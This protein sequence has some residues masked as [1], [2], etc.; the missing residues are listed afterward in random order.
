[1]AGCVWRCCCCCV[2][3]F[4]SKINNIQ[5]IRN[6]AAQTHNLSNHSYICCGLCTLTP[7][8]SFRVYVS[9]CGVC[10]CAFVWCVCVCVWLFTSV[11]RKQYA[12]HIGPPKQKAIY[13]KT[14]AP[15]FVTHTHTNVHRV[16]ADFTCITTCLNVFAKRESS[17]RMFGCV[18]VCLG[19]VCARYCMF[20]TY[21]YFALCIR[22]RST[23]RR[24]KTTHT[25]R[26][27]ILHQIS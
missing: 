4:S 1:M 7:P 26:V 5:N 17:V 12:I 9:G 23:L 25:L 8:C 10:V 18:C 19:Y 27:L 11:V 13:H 2:W 6:R 14:F 24:T 21:K 16:R 20:I 3:L 22:T 15:V